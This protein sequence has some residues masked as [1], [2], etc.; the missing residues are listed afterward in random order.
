MY[1]RVGGVDC[2][3]DRNVDIVQGFMGVIVRLSFFDVQEFVDLMSDKV[4]PLGVRKSD[5]WLISG[6]LESR[7]IGR[8]LVP[9]HLTNI[10]NKPQMNPIASETNALSSYGM[11]ENS[12]RAAVYMKEQLGIWSNY[13]FTN[14]SS[15]TEEMMDLLYCEAGL[16]ARCPK[17]ESRISATKLLD[18]GL[19]L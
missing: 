6:Y 3:S 5:D 12:M 17:G 13:T 8:V 19:A 15:L 18:E 9:P 16:A 4:L 1:F 14:A 10:N 2:H 11:H 7:G